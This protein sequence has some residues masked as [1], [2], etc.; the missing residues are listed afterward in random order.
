MISVENGPYKA[1]E[2]IKKVNIPGRRYPTVNV[3][4]LWDRDEAVRLQ[5]AVRGGQEIVPREIDLLVVDGNAC[6]E[7]G[8]PMVPVELVTSTAEEAAALHFC[9]VMKLPELVGYYYRDKREILG[10]GTVP[11]PSERV[12][13][14][15]AE[16][17]LVGQ[18][19]MRS[20]I[21]SAS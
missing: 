5:D 7:L 18:H 4:T 20:F 6:Y 11:V 19:F 14:T 16:L 12:E 1:W 17:Q 2:V 9:A 13:F 3:A 15:D 8:V 10:E 21:A